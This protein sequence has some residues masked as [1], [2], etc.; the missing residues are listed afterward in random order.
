MKRNLDLIRTLGRKLEDEL[1]LNVPGYNRS[2]I[3]QHL[4]LMQ[5]A[6]LI[7]ALQYRDGTSNDTRVIVQR[8]TNK[9]HDFIELSR[10]QKLWKKFKLKAAQAGGGMTID[11]A[12]EVLATWLKIAILK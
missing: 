5:E 4:I 6:G 2:Q 7:Q 9:G 3:D 12:S 10:N 8:V 11:I 1:P